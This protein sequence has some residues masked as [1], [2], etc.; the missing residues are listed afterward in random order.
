M[1]DEE[2]GTGRSWRRSV[3]TFSSLLP[4][5]STVNHNRW[6]SSQHPS[7]I[8]MYT[9]APLSLHSLF[10]GGGIQGL[11]KRRG[12]THLSAGRRQNSERGLRFLT[13][14][15]LVEGCHLQAVDGLGF[16]MVLPPS[17]P[18]GR[19]F[20]VFSPIAFGA[21]LKNDPYS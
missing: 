14:G 5:V 7:A 3:S 19:G 10:S 15:G 1:A 21:S 9:P 2:K 4:S 13:R 16:T 20:R 6:F 17:V 11:P 12:F 8:G 18:A